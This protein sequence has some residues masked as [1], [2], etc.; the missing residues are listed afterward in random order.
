ML[1][2]PTVAS[3]PSALSTNTG[4]SASKKSGV[5]GN[6]E[7]RAMHAADGAGD[8][9][10]AVIGKRC[11]GLNQWLLANNAQAFHFLPRATGIFNNPVPRNHLCSHLTDVFDGDEIGK[12]VDPIVCRRLLGEVLGLNGDFKLRL[13]H[14]TGSSMR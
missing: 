5:I 7:I 13:R 2:A 12:R 10:A 9:G 6:T 8:P 14:A 11:T 1:E 3:G 4:I